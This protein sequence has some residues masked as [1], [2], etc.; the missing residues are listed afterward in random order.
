MLTAELTRAARALLN[1]TQ[2]QLAQR[3]NLGL[4][5]L[6]DFEAGRR[7]PAVNNLAAIQTALENA[8]IRFVIDPMSGRVAVGRA[9]HEDFGA[10]VADPG[11]PAGV[12]R[13]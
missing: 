10:V 3:S 4:S 2:D 7:T 9:A 13:V 5:T 8:G 11:W 12:R 6:K 1:W